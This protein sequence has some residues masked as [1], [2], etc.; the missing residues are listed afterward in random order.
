MPRQGDTKVAG[1]SRTLIHM[2]TASLE[3]EITDLT[4]PI[5]HVDHAEYNRTC[6]RPGGDLHDV[7]KSDQRM[8]LSVKHPTR[9]SRGTSVLACVEPQTAW[10]ASTIPA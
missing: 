7:R 1:N 6:T 10:K 3:I 2:V 9:P 5:R 8:I 4:P